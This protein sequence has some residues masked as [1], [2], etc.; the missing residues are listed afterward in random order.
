MRQGRRCVNPQG[1]SRWRRYTLWA[2][3]YN[4]AIHAGRPESGSADDPGARRAAWS[5]SPG[6]SVTGW[7]FTS[8]EQA[9]PIKVGTRLSRRLVRFSAPLEG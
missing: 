9:A 5:G 7:R 6:E 4:T 3:E 2:S 8:P 1:K